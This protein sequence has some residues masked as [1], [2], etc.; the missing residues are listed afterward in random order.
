MDAFLVLV[1]IALYF[2]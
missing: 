2:I 1:I